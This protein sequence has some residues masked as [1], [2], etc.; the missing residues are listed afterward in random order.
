MVR[1]NDSDDDPSNVALNR[2]RYIQ[3]GTA[4]VV[5]GSSLLASGT[6]AADSVD[7]QTNL[8]N[9][10]ISVSNSDIEVEHSVSIT[11][12]DGACLSDDWV[13]PFQI[14]IDTI[15]YDENDS[16]VPKDEA[17][18][19]NM[20]EL[21]FPDNTVRKENDDHD[22]WGGYPYEETN[23][24]DYSA[25][26]EAAV[27]FGVSQLS[28][29]GW[30]VDGAVVVTEMLQYLVEANDSTDSIRA[31][32]VYYDPGR[33]PSGRLVPQADSWG[34]FEAEFDADW[35]TIDIRHGFTIENGFDDFTF[36][37]TVSHTIGADKFC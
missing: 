14:D 26:A 30:V 9:D 5:G 12:F 37:D 29:F 19:S 2:R 11:E 24:D 18:R 8:F 25:F 20:F 13:Q 6:A 32:F 27:T 35:I 33:T 1:N 23:G 36:R 22:E 16:S 34:S 7:S 31:D 17:I 28:P 10:T 3:A 4:G 21:T 15:A